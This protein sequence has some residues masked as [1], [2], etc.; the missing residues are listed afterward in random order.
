MEDLYPYLKILAIVAVIASPF[1]RAYYK[2]RNGDQTESFNQST[3]FSSKSKSDHS[4]N[5]KNT[6]KRTIS[7]DIFTPILMLL[8]L[9]SFI[10]MIY[11]NFFAD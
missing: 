11:D 9:L 7:F 10:Y 5:V 3:N 8:F 2:Q 6:Q 1:V 4:S